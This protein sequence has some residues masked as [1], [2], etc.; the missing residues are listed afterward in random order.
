ME[1]DRR[2]HVKRFDRHF[3]YNVDIEE[4]PLE[5]V[6]LAGVVGKSFASM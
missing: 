1:L 2:Y 6:D 3:D 4:S 5:R